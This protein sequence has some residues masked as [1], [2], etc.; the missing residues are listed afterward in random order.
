MNKIMFTNFKRKIA[1]KNEKVKKKREKR[2]K[3]KKRK[4]KKRKRKTGSEL[5]EGSQN[6]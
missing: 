6:Q 4:K 1:K 2:K 5:L 3:R